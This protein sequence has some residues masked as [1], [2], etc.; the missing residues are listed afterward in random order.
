MNW[1]AQSRQNERSSKPYPGTAGPPS[2]ST[3]TCCECPQ[4]V[5]ESRGSSLVFLVNVRQCPFGVRSHLQGKLASQRGCHQYPDIY[6]AAHN[7]QHHGQRHSIWSLAPL[8]S[9]PGGRQ[10]ILS[11]LSYSGQSLPLPPMRTSFE[12]LVSSSQ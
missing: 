6:L 3:Q 10:V 5:W 8:L 9:Q 12:P 4:K 7:F 1:T 11:T 2:F